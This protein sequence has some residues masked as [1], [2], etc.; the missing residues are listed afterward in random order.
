MSGIRS[1]NKGA[2][3]SDDE[4]I[5]NAVT[6]L[7]SSMKSAVFRNGGERGRVGFVFIVQYTCTKNLNNSTYYGTSTGSI[8][9]TV[10]RYPIL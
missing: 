6:H 4:K 1:S 10:Y 5:R 9:H 8:T 7:N 3:T 2:L